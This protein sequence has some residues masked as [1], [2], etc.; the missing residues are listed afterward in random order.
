[1]EICWIIKRQCFHGALSKRDKKGNFHEGI[2]NINVYDYY[3]S[4]IKGFLS[5]FLLFI[6]CIRLVVG[7][8]VNFNGE[9]MIGEI[10]LLIED[11]NV[12]GGNGFNAPSKEI[13]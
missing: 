5:I 7:I 2:L 10:I 13:T 11:L 1:M 8:C 12:D 3:E 6:W 9:F 4:A